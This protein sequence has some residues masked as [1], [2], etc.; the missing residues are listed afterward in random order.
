MS[1]N[2]SPSSSS[3]NGEEKQPLYPTI[4]ELDINNN[5]NNN[6]NNNSNNNKQKKEKERSYN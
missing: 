3:S 1:D 6:N 5:N 2:H 4:E